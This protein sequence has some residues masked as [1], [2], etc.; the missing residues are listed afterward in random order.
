MS[1]QRE[2]C[3]APLIT[4]VQFKSPSKECLSPS[5]S[6]WCSSLPKHLGNEIEQE[7]VDIRTPK[8]FLIQEKE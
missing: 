7:D 5:L 2:L 6:L 1:V 3:R 4:L 8:N